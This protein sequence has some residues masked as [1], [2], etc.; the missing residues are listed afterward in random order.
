MRLSDIDLRLLRVFEAVAAS[1]GFVKAKDVLGISQPALSAYIAKL[2]DRLNV[3]LCE[4]G[5]Q[6]FS[7]TPQG[8][9]VLAEARLLLDQFD[10]V[11]ARLAN[12][13]KATAQ[14]LRFGIVDCLLSEGQNPLVPAIRALRAV[15]PA[16]DVKIGIYDFL[17]CL[18]EL[19]SGRLDI[20]VVGISDDEV[21]PDDLEER[22]VF[23]EDSGLYCAP[24]HPCS[25]ISDPA[26]LRKALEA[27][28][29]SAHSFLS[30]PIDD[31][32][33]VGLL[34]PSNEIAQD[35]IESTV[36]LTLAGTHVG[37]IPHHSSW[38]EAQEL[39]NI[40][41]DCSAKAL[42]AVDGSQR[43]ESAR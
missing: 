26:A 4:R 31:A 40:I 14:S 24:D 10:E 2:E 41:D 16:L 8:D 21:V 19:R 17:D 9:Q 15:R 43:R 13:G 6:G 23:V 3:R 38:A 33:N 18:T 12:I 29:I 11:G 27:A 39:T 28:N 34:D 22:E 20:A 7:L 42:A 37:L 1:G 36:Y 25:S 30:N 5:P 32:L 35:T